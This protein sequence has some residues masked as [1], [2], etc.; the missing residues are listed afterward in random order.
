MVM[1]QLS[2]EQRRARRKNRANKCDKETKLV[3]EGGS[4]LPI[5]HVESSSIQTSTTKIKNV[6]ET[7]F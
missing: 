1:S 2:V 7:F 3:T 6:S 5:I 4:D